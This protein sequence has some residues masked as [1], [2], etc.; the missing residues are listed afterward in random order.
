VETDKATVE[1][2][3]TALAGA[4][5][6]ERGNQNRRGTGGAGGEANAAIVHSYAIEPATAAAMAKPESHR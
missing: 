3:R 4:E 6:N 1:F 5:G 2:V